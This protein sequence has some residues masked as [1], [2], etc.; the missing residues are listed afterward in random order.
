VQNRIIALFFIKMP[1]LFLNHEGLKIA[2]SCSFSV[3]CD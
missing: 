1:C 3:A 2:I